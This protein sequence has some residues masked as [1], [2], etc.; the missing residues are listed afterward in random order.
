MFAVRGTHMSD[1]TPLL[2]CLFGVLCTKSRPNPRVGMSLQNHAAALNAESGR[3]DAKEMTLA[4]RV[5]SSAVGRGITATGAVGSI[6]CKKAGSRESRARCTRGEPPK[7]AR[8]PLR[9]RS[10]RALAA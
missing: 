2:P 6:L 3:Q 5:L 9:A 7:A 10:R 8:L 1:A 4:G